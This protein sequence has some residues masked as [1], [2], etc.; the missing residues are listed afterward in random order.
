MGDAAPAKEADDAATGADDAKQ[1]DDHRRDSQQRVLAAMQPRPSQPMDTAAKEAAIFKAMHGSHEDVDDHD[2]DIPAIRLDHKSTIGAMRWAKLQAQVGDSS[3]DFQL[4][5]AGK[6][7][8]EETITSSVKSRSRLR[9]GAP[10][11]IWAAGKVGPDGRRAA[12]PNQAAREA[13]HREGTIRATMYRAPTGDASSTGE[14][15][16]EGTVRLQPADG[17]RRSGCDAIPVLYPDGPLRLRLAYVSVMVP[18]RIGL[19]YPAIGVWF[20]VETAIDVYF[21]LDILVNFF[22]ALY[23][24]E[25]GE[26]AAVVDQMA[27]VAHGGAKVTANKRRIAAVYLRGWFII[28]LLACAPVDYLQRGSADAIGC[29]YHPV[30]PCTSRANAAPQGQAFKLFKLLRTF[31]V[32]KLFRLFRLKRLMKKYQ[33][34]LLYWLPLIQAGKL[35][36]MLVF[37]SHWMGCA[38]ASVFPFGDDVTR[39]E[40]YVACVYWA[41]QT[42]TTVGYGDMGSPLLRCRL[43]AI[44]SMAVGALLF[45]WLIQYVLT[46]LDPDTFERK[47]QAK[48]ER[49]M[50]YLRANSL[51]MDLAQ[52]VIRHVRQ[53]NSRQSEDRAVLEALPRQLRGEIFLNLYEEHVR[54]VPLFNGVGPA[55]VADICAKLSPLTIPAGEVVYGVGDLADEGAYIVAA[56]VASGEVTMAARRVKP[57]GKRAMQHMKALGLVAQPTSVALIIEHVGPGSVFGEGSTLGCSRRIDEAISRGQT[58]LLTIPGDDFRQTLNLVPKLRWRVLKRY[59]EY[60]IKSV[61]QD[62]LVGR[63]RGLA[64][65]AEWREILVDLRETWEARFTNLEPLITSA[66]SSHAAAPAPEKQPLPRETLRAQAAHAREARGKADDVHRRIDGLEAEVA[67][68]RDDLGAKLDLLLRKPGALEPL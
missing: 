55:F 59:A 68:L 36:V 13:M 33:D 47:Q 64:I 62:K 22:T 42:I 40:R 58:E 15:N 10:N 24:T 48:I 32:L 5:A 52:R 8:D 3:K 4:L 6:E 37:A 35:L 29:S 25:M 66:P 18:V 17:A 21:I 41:M 39:S 20:M 57:P 54:T 53:Q 65:D 44:V 56:G 26:N 43:V 51:P 50:A 14:L 7:N 27:A 11:F 63:A 2:M 61:S 30:R 45:G 46:V 49:I 34:E 28:D 31:R 19:D 1:E 38:Y 9:Y 60:L 23:A 16:R 12:D 67:K